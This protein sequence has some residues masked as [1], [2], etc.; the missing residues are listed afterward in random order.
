MLSRP[1]AGILGGEKAWEQ[2]QKIG[3]VAGRETKNRKA[4]D[5]LCPTRRSTMLLEVH[6]RGGEERKRGIPRSEQQETKQR[7][8]LDSKRK[9]CGSSF[10][11]AG[12][13]GSW[14]WPSADKRDA[15]AEGRKRK[16]QKRKHCQLSAGSDGQGRDIKVVTEDDKRMG[17]KIRL[18]GGATKNSG[19]V[20]EDVEK[21]GKGAG[22]EGTATPPAC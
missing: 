16:Q 12:V 13:P 22:E 4:R 14:G 17:P 15:S 10:R 9:D 20:W 19:Q 2:K 8:N 6:R 11:V 18:L 21:R 5:I 3:V 1:S 7:L